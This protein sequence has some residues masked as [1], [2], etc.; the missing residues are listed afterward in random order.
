MPWY[1]YLIM[2]GVV[3]AS[4][5]I[6][7]INFAV[8]ISR[9]VNRDVRQSGSGNAGTMNMLRTYGL[10]FGIATLVLDVLKGAVCSLIGWFFLGGQMLA[11]GFDKIGVFIAGLACIIGHIYP[12]FYK[13]RGG[14]GVACAIGV[15]LVADPIIALASFAVALAFFLVVKIGSLASF[16]ATGIPLVYEGVRYLTAGNVLCG[17]LALAIF[18]IVLVAHRQNLVRIFT[19]KER[20]IDLFKKKDKD[21][22]EPTETKEENIVTDVEEVPREDEAK[23]VDPEETDGE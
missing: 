20:K 23:V 11:F 15:A 18:A 14:K 7:S 1:Y 22:V 5:C 8:I 12:S 16:I 6:G 17:L 19:G 10:K 3:V 2:A 21:N 9:A 13:F 4:Y